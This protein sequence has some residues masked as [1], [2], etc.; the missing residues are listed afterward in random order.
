MVPSMR[1]LTDKIIIVCFSL[2]P[3]PEP[4]KDWQN[5]SGTGVNMLDLMF[6]DGK[7]WSGTFQLVS[8]LSRFV[9]NICY[10]MKLKGCVL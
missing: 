6:Q 5:V 4:V 8:S 3:V 10:Y 2:A 9:L 1:H 7:R